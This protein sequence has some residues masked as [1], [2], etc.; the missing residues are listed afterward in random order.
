MARLVYSSITSSDSY[1]VDERGSFDWSVPDE[2]VHAL[3]NELQRPIGTYLYG[4]RLYEVMLAWETLPTAGE[5]GYLHDFAQ[6][7]RA[8]DKLGYSSTLSS[9]LSARTRIVERFD[10]DEVRRWQSLPSRPS[11]PHSGAVRRAPLR[12]R[13]GLP[14]VRNQDLTSAAT[15]N[16][17]P[18]FSRA[19]CRAPGWRPV[20]AKPAARLRDTPDIWRVDSTSVKFAQGAAREAAGRAA[21]QLSRPER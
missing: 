9:V 16:A 21:R 19:T 15:L 3:V 2:E 12:E 5:P 14:Q 10:P 4:R 8:A 18:I 11:P 17:S 20:C 1:I 7:W 6:I 13:R